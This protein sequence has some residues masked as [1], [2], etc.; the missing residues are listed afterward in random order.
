MVRWD[1]HVHTKHSYDCRS[2]IEDVLK[3]ACRRKLDGI[4]IT[5]HDSVEAWREVKKL[6]PKYDL[7]TIPG[8]EYKTN[9]GDL[10]VY[11]IEEIPRPF[12][13]L[14]EAIELFHHQ[15]G[16]L[17]AAHPYDPL[18]KGIG[19][20]LNK[21]KIDG[22]EAI[23][24]HAFYGNTKAIRFAERHDMTML[25]ASDAHTLREIGHATTVF[26]GDFFKAL[27]K[28][29]TVAEGAFWFRTL[30]LALGSGLLTVPSRLK[31]KWKRWSIRRQYTRFS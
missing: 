22:I 12:L 28:G 19:K 8:F 5:D 25:G 18:R 27:K 1:T 31:N 17:V 9:Q 6:A 24:S 4:I 3:V 23:N 7:K 13:D 14:E 26:K 21:V 30:P 29:E 15:G 11:G 20:F 16:L 10:L 2:R